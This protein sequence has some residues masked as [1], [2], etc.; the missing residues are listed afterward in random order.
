MQDYSHFPFYKILCCSNHML[1]FLLRKQA[2]KHHQNFHLQK[3]VAGVFL[4]AIKHYL[5]QVFKE[6]NVFL[7][8]DGGW[9]WD[10][11]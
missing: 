3:I 2:L 4:E 5:L 9:R 1:Q 11:G 8:E 6:R 7:V 10:N